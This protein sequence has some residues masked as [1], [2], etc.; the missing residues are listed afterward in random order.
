[1]SPK[2]ESDHQLPNVAVILV[3]YNTATLTTKAVESVL[4]S[5]GVHCQVFVVDNASSDRTVA[6]MRRK[7][8]LKEDRKAWQWMRDYASRPNQ[9]QLFSNVER[10]IESIEGCLTASVGDH[11][12]TLLLSRDNLGFGRANNV[13]AATCAPDYYFF[14]NSDAEIEPHTIQTMIEAFTPSAP[15]SGS[16]LARTRSR[17]DNPG[18]VAAQ[19]YNPDGTLQRQ[20][21]AL[22]NL[23]NVFRWITFLD[24]IPALG[25]VLGSYQH[26][27]EDMRRIQ[28]SGREKVGWAGG[29]AFMMS[30]MCLA[31]IGCF[32]P[33]I[34][35]YGEDI[36]LCWRATQRHWDVAIV[37]AGKVIHHGTAS[38][39]KKSAL[40]GEISG[41]VYL[42]QKYHSGLEQRFFRSILRFGLYLR[43]V[44]FGI[45]RQ[46]GRQRIY[47]EALAL[48]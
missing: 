1:M 24:D 46:Y 47:Q 15:R 9:Q 28:R 29:T 25:F 39:T 45:L 23:G 6:Q 41:L 4:S 12:V 26:H 7:F 19:L 14:L 3:S 38:G 40:H 37:V 8:G 42:W 48:V 27:D 11:E 22:P 5:A 43:I 21:G 33:A 10:D 36:E 31:E 20:G 13:V 2:T 16:V 17:L 35:M 34:F 30:K 32:D 44:V 18:I